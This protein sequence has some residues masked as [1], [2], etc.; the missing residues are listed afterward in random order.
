MR[1]T[2]PV[3]LAIGILV[4]AGVLSA[5]PYGTDVFASSTSRN[6]FRISPT[7]QVTTVVTGVGGTVNM[8]CMDNDNQS[9]VIC[10]ASPPALYRV[11]P[12]QNAIVGTIWSGAPLTY[13]DYFN[14][15]STGD[16]LVADNTQVWVVK[17]DG[18][19][20]TTIRMGSPFQNLQGCI[21]DVATG[22]FAMGDITADAVFMVAGDGT[23]VSTHA[24]PSMNPFSLTQDPR[25]GAL[26]VGNGGAGLVHRL[27]TNISALTTVSA[28]AGNAN[29]ICFDRWSG[30]GEIVVGTTT[31]YRMDIK[32]TVITFHTGIPG[33]NSGMCFD[34]GRNIVPVKTG[35]PNNYKFDIHIPGQAG[36]GYVFGLSTSG[37]T[38]GIPLG[39]RVIPL[40]LDNVLVLSLQGTLFPLLKN[41]IGTLDPFDRA[42]AT[43]DLSGFGSLLKGLRVW[44]AAIALNPAAPGG[45][46]V[47]TKPYVIVLE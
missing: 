43:L 7:G 12:L 17:H 45:I 38:P 13:V 6:L 9:V 36:M 34:K 15:T 31:V 26:I 44:S 40:V 5:Q 22:Y 37:F 25:D 41:N 16:F 11:D 18:S 30:N 28:S 27:D 19:T 23:V 47:V 4:T 2:L 21:E 14:P 10:Q 1:N 8:V 35:T 33:T 29:A 46:A 20:V 32:G 39:S 3:A 42:T 24:F